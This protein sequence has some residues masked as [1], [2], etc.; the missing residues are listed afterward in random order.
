MGGSAGGFTALNVAIGGPE[1]VSAVVALYPVTDLLNLAATTH[2]FEAGDLARLVGPLP[3]ARGQYVERS[4]A[5]RARDL[6]V[7]LLMLQGRNDKVVSAEQT[8]AFASALR[9]AGATVEY[10]EYEDEGHGWRHAATIEDEL[11]RIHAF[12]ARWC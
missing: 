6:R 11:T 7:P 3:D 5:S 8:A 9:S 10:H 2:R 12:L 4:P 1:L